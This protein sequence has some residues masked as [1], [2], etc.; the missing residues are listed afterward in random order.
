MREN[1]WQMVRSWGWAWASGRG[2]V[3][4]GGKTDQEDSPQKLA[5]Q[6]KPQGGRQVNQVAFVFVYSFFF[7]NGL[8]LVT[9][10]Q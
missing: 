10:E 7:L 4:E 2:G 5:F 8:T 1:A 6:P 3:G 9:N